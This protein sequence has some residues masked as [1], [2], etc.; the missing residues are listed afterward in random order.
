MLNPLFIISLGNLLSIYMY[1]TLHQELSV[2]NATTS[3]II[4]VFKGV[5]IMF[6][7][8]WKRGISKET[9]NHNTIIYGKIQVRTH[10]Y[11]RKENKYSSFNPG[12][13][14]SV[15][16]EMPLR[17]IGKLAELQRLI[18]SQPIKKDLCIP[19]NGKLS[20]KAWLCEKECMVF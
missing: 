3:R 11:G 14:R 4:P 17:D 1:H 9:N 10:F 18:Q 5:C 8:I 15:K 12:K 16:Q 13:W 2:K 7:F 19:N 20:S 6:Y